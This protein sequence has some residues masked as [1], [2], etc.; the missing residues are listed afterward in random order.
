MAACVLYMCSA[1]AQLAKLSQ[2]SL[3][4][5]ILEG[6][7]LCMVT[8]P[9]QTPTYA[10]ACMNPLFTPASKHLQVQHAAPTEAAMPGDTPQDHTDS[11]LEDLMQQLQAE[12]SS[13]SRAGGHKAL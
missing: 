9:M 3:Q 11:S 2:F 13:S 8:N 12:S 4:L 5:D 1:I 7:V 6:E 10:C